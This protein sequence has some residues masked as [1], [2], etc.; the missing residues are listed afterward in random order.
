MDGPAVFEIAA[1]P[2]AKPVEPSLFPAQ[3]HHVGQGLGRMQMPAVPGVDD[4]DTGI[5]RRGQ[6]RTGDR[7]PHGDDVGIPADHPDGVFK[8]F[9]L[10]DGGIG[11][12]VE[13][14]DPAAQPQHRGLEGHL[15]T[16]GRFIKQR[17]QDFS[18]AYAVI[19]VQ[20]IPDITGEAGDLFP[21]PRG[22]IGDINEMP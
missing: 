6:R 3:C 17:G 14:D 9:P 16:G 22:Q 13:S 10:G 5:Q 11:R 2:D 1:K 4:W 15:C 19:L 21:F 12:V 18:P 20:V 7:M 8:G